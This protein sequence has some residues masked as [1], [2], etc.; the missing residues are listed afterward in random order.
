MKKNKLNVDRIVHEKSII[1]SNDEAKMDL[2][3]AK[4]ILEAIDNLISINRK[5]HIKKALKRL[6]SQET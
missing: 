1:Y 2:V 5:S 3:N 4:L 6:S